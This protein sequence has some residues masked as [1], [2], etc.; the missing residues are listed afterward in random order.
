MLPRLSVDGVLVREIRRHQDRRGWLSELFRQD[1]LDREFHPVMSYVSMT[2]PGITR[3]PHEH[4]DQADLFCFIGPST[5][6]IYLWDNRL[7]S[8]THRI[9]DR[10]EAGED[11]P[12]MVL[13]PKGVVHAYKN[14]GDR[15]G[16][17]INCPNRLY[18]GGGRNEPVD[19][20]RYE[21]DPDGRFRVD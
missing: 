6:R 19:E 18:G 17:V 8:K 4:A 14:V 3:G 16:I 11:N 2:H 21:D 10:F 7:D 9:H 20:I 13:I 12:L 1:Q 5:F 15:E